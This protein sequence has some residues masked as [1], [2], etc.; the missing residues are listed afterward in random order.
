[1]GAHDGRYVGSETRHAGFDEAK[2]MGA[3]GI[4][5]DGFFRERKNL[6]K[7]G[8]RKWSAGGGRAGDG[9]HHDL[10]WWEN[11]VHF[12][13]VHVLCVMCKYQCDRLVLNAC[14]ELQVVEGVGNERVELREVQFIDFHDGVMNSS[15]LLA[16]LGEEIV[17]FDHKRIAG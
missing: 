10:G 17:R 12:H 5:G 11:V 4:E 14:D 2:K 1:M 13:L 7:G 15:N 6:G 9:D 3:I 16:D 8:R